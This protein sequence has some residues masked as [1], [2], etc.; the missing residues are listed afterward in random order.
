MT[1]FRSAKPVCVNLFNL[2]TWYYESIINWWR[3]PTICVVFFDSWTHVLSIIRK[4]SNIPFSNLGCFRT[5]QML[6][7]SHGQNCWL[8]LFPRKP[9]VGVL[10]P[11]HRIGYFIYWWSHLPVLT[12]LCYLL[13][14]EAG[15]CV[16]FSALDV[17]RHRVKER[18][19]G[20]FRP[21]CFGTLKAK[22]DRETK[23]TGPFF[24]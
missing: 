21:R 6:M 8:G 9:C 24:L 12:V 13:R 5:G 17:D 11:G 7:L 3:V 16:L 23:Y 19:D 2:L 15:P 14:Q 18:R 10:S 1:G 20:A 22:K 4:N